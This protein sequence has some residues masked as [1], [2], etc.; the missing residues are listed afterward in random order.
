[1]TAEDILNKQNC[2]GYVQGEVFGDFYYE[3]SEIIDAMKEYARLKC[4]E[5]LKI[6]AEKAKASI[7]YTYSGNVGEYRDEWAIINK[8]S[9]LNAVDLNEFIK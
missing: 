9:I 4:E 1:M 7:E 6:V 2:N 3:T 8:D 5:L